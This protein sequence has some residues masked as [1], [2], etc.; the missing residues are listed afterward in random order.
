MERK[1]DSV[2]S[3]FTKMGTTEKSLKIYEYSEHSPMDSDPDRFARDVSAF[4]E[5][6]NVNQ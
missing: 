5:H 6:Y 2:F 1:I 4:I 3:V